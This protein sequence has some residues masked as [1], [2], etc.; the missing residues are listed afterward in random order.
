MLEKST[1]KLDVVLHIDFLR[2]HV[3]SPLL[4]LVHQFITMI[5][6]ARDTKRF[7]GMDQKI[8]LVIQTPNSNVTTTTWAQKYDSKGDLKLKFVYLKLEVVEWILLSNFA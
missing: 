2:Q 8:P 4:R 1:T 7:L 6:C 5:Y 3:N